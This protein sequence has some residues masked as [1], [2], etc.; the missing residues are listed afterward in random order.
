MDRVIARSRATGLGSGQVI[1]KSRATGQWTGYSEGIVEPLGSGQ[2][3][4]RA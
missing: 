2:V 4:A 1:A 3:I